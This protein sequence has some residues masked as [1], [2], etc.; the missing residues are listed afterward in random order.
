MND[1]QHSFSLIDNNYCF[2]LSKVNVFIDLLPIIINYIEYK[3]Y[4]E[5]Y[6]SP[7]NR[8]NTSVYCCDWLLKSA[9]PSYNTAWRGFGHSGSP[10]IFA[11]T[12]YQKVVEIFS[13]PAYHYPTVSGQTSRMPGALSDE[14]SRSSP[15]HFLYKVLF[16]KT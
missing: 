15:T 1:L 6:H 16:W 3:V 8:S 7:G 10:P 9:P 14:I 12:H 5:K 4:L 11:S 13:R 2:L